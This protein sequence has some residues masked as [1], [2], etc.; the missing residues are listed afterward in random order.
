[1]DETAE[2]QAE[3]EKKSKTMIKSTDQDHPGLFEWT[4]AQFFRELTPEEL[5]KSVRF[6]GMGNTDG[7]F[8]DSRDWQ[9]GKGYRPKIHAIP[10]GFEETEIPFTDIYPTLRAYLEDYEG[11]SDDG[12]NFRP[13]PNAME[14]QELVGRLTNPNAKWDYWQIGGRWENYLRLVPDVAAVGK[15]RTLP[16]A[17]TPVFAT[18]TKRGMMDFEA[19]AEVNVSPQLAIYDR[20]AKILAGEHFETFNA[21]MARHK[22]D[23]SIDVRKAYHEQ[24]LLVRLKA[25]LTLNENNPFYDYDDLVLDRDAF[26]RLKAFEGYST[27][28]L[29]ING[30]WLADKRMGWF[31]C[32]MP[33]ENDREKDWI[34]TYNDALGSI[35]EDHT[36][37]IVDCHT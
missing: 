9:D 19:M 15:D 23:K 18:V 31:G 32:S 29:L 7:K 12:G 14:G 16:V 36:V 6:I 3:Y 8:H 33:Q 25:E 35:P 5:T 11:Y 37:V 4:D 26:I 1:V 20:A 27:F 24:A 17:Q 30:E 21:V 34:D 28:A 10:E 13:A 22:R 2:K